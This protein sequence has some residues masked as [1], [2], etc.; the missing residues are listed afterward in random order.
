MKGFIRKAAAVL[1]CAAG[2]G[3]PRLLHLPRSRG[4][5]LP[6]AL[7][8]P[9]AQG[10][11]RVRTRPQVQNGHVL[12]QTVWNYDFEPGTDKLTGGGLRTSGVHGP[13]PAA[14]LTPTVYLQTAQDVAYDPA[15]P[16]ELAA[17]QARTGRQAR[18]GHPEVS[19]RPDRRPA[20]RVHG[21]DPRPVGSG[22]DGRLGFGRELYTCFGQSSGARLHSGR[23]RRRAAGSAGRCRSA[24]LQEPAAAA[25]L[26]RTANTAETGP[27]LPNGQASAAVTSTVL[28]SPTSPAWRFPSLASFVANQPTARQVHSHESNEPQ[29][30]SREKPERL[31]S[32]SL[33]S[34]AMSWL[35][36]G[37]SVSATSRIVS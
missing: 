27:V 19:R 8:L 23:R 12:D 26:H 14:R 10:S 5:V 13:P 25:A 9:G 4:S 1:C 24:R 30:A 36:S 28:V 34:L 2:V 3:R 21:A 17:K 31:F 29:R 33:D 7:Q 6:R 22:C 18:R 15:N 20:R 32:A 11:R 35:L 16:D 37:L